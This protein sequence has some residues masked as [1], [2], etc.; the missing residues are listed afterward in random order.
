MTHGLVSLEIK[1]GFAMKTNRKQYL[2]FFL[3]IVIASILWAISMDRNEVRTHDVSQLVPS[4]YDSV[5]TNDFV[6]IIGEEEI[7]IEREDFY[8]TLQNGS[9]YKLSYGAEY[10]LE[11]LYN[12]QWYKVPYLEDHHLFPLTLLGLDPHSSR[13]LWIGLAGHEV[14]PGRYRIVK[15]FFLGIPL[16]KDGKGSKEIILASFEFDLY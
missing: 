15:E 13:E 4:K 2:I 8:V 1:E 7:S 16:G 9:D 10:V 14:Y 12:E 6:E 11:V 3:A 5:I